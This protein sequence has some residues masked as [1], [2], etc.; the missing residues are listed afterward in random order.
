MKTSRIEAVN[1]VLPSK[2]K[3]V[4]YCRVNT[5]SDAQHESL[6]TQKAHYESFIKKI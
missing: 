2:L 6:E 5:A 1:H 3:V 4:A